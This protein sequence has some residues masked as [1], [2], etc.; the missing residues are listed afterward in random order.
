MI[1]ATDHATVPSRSPASGQS[2]AARV[3]SAEPGRRALSEADARPSLGPAGQFPDLRPA[4]GSRRWPERVPFDTGATSAAPPEQPASATVRELPG[5]YGRPVW[6]T[7]HGCG[8]IRLPF[9][10]HPGNPRQAGRCRGGWA[11]TWAGRVNAPI[12]GPSWA[13]MSPG[14]S[15]RPIARRSCGTWHLASGAGTSWQAW[16]RCSPCCAGCPPPTNRAIAQ[17][18]CTTSVLDQLSG[19]KPHLLTPGRLLPQSARHHRDTAW[20]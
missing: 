3:I 10:D 17:R 2:R 9:A 12:S 7:G 5:G 20:S 13:C 11:A 14:R 4:A 16:P 15:P 6:P 8:R 1:S 19:G 18:T